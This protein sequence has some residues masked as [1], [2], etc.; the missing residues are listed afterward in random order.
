MGVVVTSALLV[1]SPVRVEAQLATQPFAAYGSAAAVAL[2]AVALGTTQVANTQVAMSAGVVNSTGLS[3]TVNNQYGQ[4]VGPPQPG[5]NAYGR[6]T[7]VE[8]GLLTPTVQAADVNQIKLAQLAEANAAPPSPLITKEIPISLPG[9]LTATTARGQAQATY[10]PD[11]CPVGRPLTYGLGFVENLQVLP[12]ATGGLIG[13]SATGNSVTQTRT[14]TYMVPNGDGTYGV[15]AESQAIVAPVSVAGTNITI[16]IAGPVG[17]R[18]TATGKPGDPRNGVAYTGTPVL[19]VRAGAATLLTLSLQD[20]LGAGGV[21][22]PIPP[23]LTL[24][25]GAPPVGLNGT[26]APSVAADGTSASGSADTLRLQLLTLPGISALDVGLG[27]FEGAVS[28]P[29]GGVRCTLPVSKVANPD[30]VAVGQ[31]VTFTISIPSDPGLFNALF[32]CDLINIRAVDTVEVASGAV[33]FNIVSAD[34]GGVVGPANRV[35]WENLGSYALGDP[36]IQLNMVVHISSAS[37]DAVIRDIV[38]VSAALGN[39]RGRAA[40]D[41]MVLG[42]GQIQGNAITGRFVLNGPTIA[43]GSLAPTGGDATPLVLGGALALGG[44]GLIRLR[45]TLIQRRI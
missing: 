36:P 9:L 22:L 4:A 25:L 39:C 40:G 27:H 31:D 24:R 8:I 38:D 20:L 26:G 37:G 16:D 32:A 41:D 18:T 14:V 3:G 35:T 6:G 5:K 17:M 29:P 21:N 2:N 1:T 28:A 10:H 33:T 43:G 19:T 7:G 12:G 15:V 34:R 13:T 30:P 11:F 23:L 44:L 42:S 45:R